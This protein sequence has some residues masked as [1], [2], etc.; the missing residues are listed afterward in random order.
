MQLIDIASFDSPNE[1]GILESIL[2]AENIPYLL[3]RQSISYF[4]PG[5]GGILSID[6]NDKERVVKIFKEAGFGRYLMNYEL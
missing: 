5:S 6:V 1:T 3:N 2:T 4:F